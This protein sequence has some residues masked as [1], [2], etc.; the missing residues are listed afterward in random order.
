M[1]YFTN[2]LGAALGVLASGFWLIGVVGLPG[3]VMTAG[4]IN[5]LLAAIRV[6]AGARPEAVAPPAAPLAAETARDLATRHDSSCCAA[7]LAGMAAFIYEIAWIRMLSMVLGSSTHAFELMLSAFILGLALGGLWIRQPHRSAVASAAA[8]LAVMF[9][10][11]AVLATLTLPAYGFDLRRD[12]RRRCASSTP[13]T[14]GYAGSTSSATRSPRHHDPDHVH[15]GH[16]TAA[17][18][19]LAA[20]HGPTSAPSARYTPAN[21]VGAIAGVLL[22]VHLLLPVV[23]TQGRHML[24]G[25]ASPAG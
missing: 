20:A 10:L 9:A 1:L 22:A 3:T 2:S 18:D 4:I 25:A 8:A 13:P 7:F 15:R 21:T 16:D 11:M 6:G 14:P 23:G 17:H 12:G 5:S 19:S 24:A